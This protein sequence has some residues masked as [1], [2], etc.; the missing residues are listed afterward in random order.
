MSVND[1]RFQTTL[2][3]K[4]SSSVTEEKAKS[5]NMSSTL[6]ISIVAKYNLGYGHLLLDPL[7]IFYSKSIYRY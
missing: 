6:Q 2:Y 7:D 4:S 5:S 3:F 1:C